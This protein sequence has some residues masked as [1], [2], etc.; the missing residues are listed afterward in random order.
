MF[1]DKMKKAICFILAGLMILSV[2]GVVLSV[3]V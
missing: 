3:I 1:S 2:G